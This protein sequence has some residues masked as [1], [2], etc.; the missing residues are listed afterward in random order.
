LLTSDE[1]PSALLP[2]IGEMGSRIGRKESLYIGEFIVVILI[3]IGYKYCL[4]PLGTT[5]MYSVM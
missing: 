3:W 4:Q 1:P 5:K 2:G